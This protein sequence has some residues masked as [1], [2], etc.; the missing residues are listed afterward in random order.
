MTWASR[1][2]FTLTTDREKLPQFSYEE[3]DEEICNI[4]FTA[5][6]DNLDINRDNKDN[7]RLYI[8]SSHEGI[9]A[10]LLDYEESIGSIYVIMEDIEK[11]PD[12]LR[13]N[14]FK[15]FLHLNLLEIT[16]AQE[17]ANKIIQD[18]IGIHNHRIIKVILDNSNWLLKSESTRYLKEY[19]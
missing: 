15:P 3:I 12:L 2:S 19:S 16:D 17:E 11:I 9:E 18:L 13:Q 6:F 8:R 10:F 1:K 4:K 14:M 7:W 5:H